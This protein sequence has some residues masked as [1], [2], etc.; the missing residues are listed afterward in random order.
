MLLPK[1]EGGR[2]V[3]L[4]L[5]FSRPTGLMGML[6]SMWYRLNGKDTNA[7]THVALV[8]SFSGYLY[9]AELALNGV[10]FE[11]WA[12][13]PNSYWLCITQRNAEY[14]QYKLDVVDF[15]TTYAELQSLRVKP[16][17]TCVNFVADAL[18][19]KDHVKP[20]ALVPDLLRFLETDGRESLI[21][22]NV[23]LLF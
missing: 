16:S 12:K 11:V 4:I 8:F 6:L 9:R 20:G 17:Y 13:R 22:E 14:W 2:G 19:Y 3:D 18:N 5:E 15:C 23:D 7:G 10:N 1:A 21:A